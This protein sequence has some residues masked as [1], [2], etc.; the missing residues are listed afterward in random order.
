MLP[1]TLMFERIVVGHLAQK[2]GDY[3][4]AIMAM[5]RNLQMMFVHAYQSYLFNRIVSERIRRGLPLNEPL[6][7]DVVLPVDKDGL[8]DHDKYIPVR[9]ETEPGPGRDPGAE[10]AGLC[11]CRPIRI[12]ER[13]GEKASRAKSGD[14][15]RRQGID[16]Q[17]FVVPTILSAV[18]PA[19][20]ERSS[21]SIPELTYSVKDSDLEMGM[22][23]G[24]GC[25]ATTFLREI[26]KVDAIRE[27]SR[28]LSRIGLRGASGTSGLESREVP[29][30]SLI[31][32]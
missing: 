20:G 15:S 22:A 29:L 32:F 11:Q 16:R 8:P 10:R 28:R 13:D 24:K 6:V 31:P 2:P 25:Y 7:G 9:S 4:G 18:P 3:S 23:L 14:D 1:R 12:G 26:M 30:L 27:R 5:P 19:A 21:P 17:D